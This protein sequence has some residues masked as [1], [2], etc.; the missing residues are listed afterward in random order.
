[1]AAVSFIPRVTSATPVPQAT[2]APP[3]ALRA[4]IQQAMTDHVVPGCVVILEQADAEPW[5]EAFG[6]ADVKTGE[7]MSVDHHFRIGSITKTFTATVILQLVDEGTLQLDEPVSTFRDDIPNGDDMTLRHL[8]G[9]R[10]GLFDFLDDESVFPMLL[11]NPTRPFPP[12][13]QLQIGL[14]H[15]PDFAPG[16]RFAYS[17]TNYVL[18]QIIAE[19]AIGTPLADQIAQK[20]LSPTGLTETS[21]PA[22]PDL[23]EPFAHGYIAPP[24]ADDA[25]PVP[26][27]TPNMVDFSR[28]DPSIGGGAGALQSTVGDLRAWLHTL[29]DGSLLSED[30]QKERMTFP[31]AEKPGQLRYGLGIANMD[32]WIGHDGSILGYQG[33]MGHDP[34]SGTS[35][36]VLANIKPGPD[37]SNPANEIAYAMQRVLG[38]V[39]VSS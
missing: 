36:V 4:A 9:M 13:E 29:I 18:L 2:P 37:N 1:M 27:P 39:P 24:P 8:L 16:K 34:E 5:L 32:G 7:A 38:Y 12:E 17:N 19:Q 30:L 28:L 21:W 25:T 33:Y 15:P 22:S 23:P 26:G 3:E 31:P 11:D 14:S 6:L 35:L 20:V 10:S